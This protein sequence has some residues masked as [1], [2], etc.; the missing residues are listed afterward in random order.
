[1]RWQRRALAGLVFLS[2]LGHAADVRARPA[3]DVE[4][5]IGA[6]GDFGI[7]GLAGFAGRRLERVPPALDGHGLGR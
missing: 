3:A 7:R 4:H 2:R 6:H 1:V 5:P